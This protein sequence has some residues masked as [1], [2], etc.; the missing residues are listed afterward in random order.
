MHW[1][2]LLTRELDRGN[3]AVATGNAGKVRTCARR[4]VGIV[5][6][7]YQKRSGRNY[8][9]DAMRQLR[10][11]VTDEGLPREVR[12]AADRLQSRL[13]TDFTSRSE[14]PLEDATVIISFFEQNLLL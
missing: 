5:V 10:A 1:K 4:A 7:E 9:N 14:H 12:E 6:T 2:E 13:S 11:L 8:G 3:E